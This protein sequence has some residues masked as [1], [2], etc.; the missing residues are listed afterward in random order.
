LLLTLPLLLTLLPQ[1][2]TLLLMPLLPLLLQPTLPLTQLPLPLLQ[3]TLL[4]L[5]L[6]KRSNSRSAISEKTAGNGGFFLGTLNVPN[7][8]VRYSCQS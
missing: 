4:L 2:L 6:K 7:H 1:P 5:L 3:L 8:L